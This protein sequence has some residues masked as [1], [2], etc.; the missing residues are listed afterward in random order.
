MVSSPTMRGNV[1]LGY[2]TQVS[3]DGE[4]ADPAALADEAVARATLEGIVGRVETTAPAGAVLVYRDPAGGLSAALVRGETA[5]VLHAFPELRAATLQ[6]F[7]A[8]D[9]SLSGTTKAFLEAYSVGRFQSSVRA[10]GRHL[11]RDERELERALAGERRYA[12]LRIQPA[13]VV[14]L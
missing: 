13:P 14:T 5:A 10:F 2:G 6:V 11:P 4:H 8:H 9:L 1:G 7:S 3:L 12:R